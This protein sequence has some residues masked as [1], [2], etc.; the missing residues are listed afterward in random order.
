MRNYDV[1]LLVNNG[2]FS[3]VNLIRAQNATRYVR[4][5]RFTRVNDDF[6]GLREAEEQQQQ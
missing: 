6:Y 3:G 1:V 5:T 2:E 4:T